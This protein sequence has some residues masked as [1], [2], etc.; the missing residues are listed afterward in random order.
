M[1]QT[2]AGESLEVPCRQIEGYALMHG[3]TVAD[4]LIEAPVL[5]SVLI[6]ERQVGGPPFANFSDATS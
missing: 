2:N 4:G 1:K 5:G 3:P 6:E